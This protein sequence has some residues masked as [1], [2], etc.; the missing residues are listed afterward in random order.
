MARKGAVTGAPPLPLLPVNKRQCAGANYG[1]KR[2]PFVFSCLLLCFTVVVGIV[3]A[4]R[5]KKPKGGG[6]SCFAFVGTTTSFVCPSSFFPSPSTRLLFPPFSFFHRLTRPLSFP[7]FS[8]FFLFHYYYFFFHPFV[9]RESWQLTA[10]RGRSVVH[11]PRE[12]R[13]GW[14]CRLPRFH[15]YSLE[16]GAIASR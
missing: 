9:Q 7:L 8:S 3:S 12:V 10:T 4:E 11:G 15:Y 5:R 14:L 6:R 13:D 1:F 2:P 16:F